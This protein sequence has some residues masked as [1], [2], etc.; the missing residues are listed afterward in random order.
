MSFYTLLEKFGTP[1]KALEHLL[2][3]GEKSYRKSAH[4]WHRYKDIRGGN[5]VAG[6]KHV[7]R[8]MLK[9]RIY[10]VSWCND[11]VSLFF[12]DCIWMDKITG[13]DILVSQT[14]CQVVMY[15]TN[16]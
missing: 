9:D 2:D 8:E 14:R 1:E 15:P 5:N 10:T 4:V 6:A 16:A 3:E 11:S 12:H 7:T 13:R